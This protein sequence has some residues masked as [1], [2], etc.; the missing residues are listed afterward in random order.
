MV[1]QTEL[2]NTGKTAD[3]NNK[4]TWRICRT[5]LIRE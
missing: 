4:T 2:R 1:A 5:Q 3:L